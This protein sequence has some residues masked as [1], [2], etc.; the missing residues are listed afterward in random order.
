MTIIQT[1]GG[2]LMVLSVLAFAF[3]EAKRGKSPI[4]FVLFIIGTVLALWGGE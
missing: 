1:I 3:E 4:P 2:L